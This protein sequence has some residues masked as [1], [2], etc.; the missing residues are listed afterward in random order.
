MDV[1]PEMLDNL[2]AVLKP[3][4]GL[5]LLVSPARLTVQIQAHPIEGQPES[6]IK[7]TVMID[8]KDLSPEQEGIV[9]QVLRTVSPTVVPLKSA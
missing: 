2:A 6:V 1:T 9:T 3:I 5:R 8:G 7:F 4:L